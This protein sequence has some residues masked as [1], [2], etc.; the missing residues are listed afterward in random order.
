MRLRQDLPERISYPR[1][2]RRTVMGIFRIGF[3]KEP[4]ESGAAAINEKTL[5]LLEISADHIRESHQ[6]ALFEFHNLDLTVPFNV[7]RGRVA[8]CA[9]R[10]RRYAPVPHNAMGERRGPPR[11]SQ[12]N[13]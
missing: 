7:E 13:G 3:L 10:A 2:P 1:I 9:E 11:P 8:Q 5:V 6:G 4:R 12:P